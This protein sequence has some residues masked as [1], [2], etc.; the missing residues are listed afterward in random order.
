MPQPPRVSSTQ[1][2]W[3]GVAF[4]VVGIAVTSWLQFHPIVSGEAAMRFQVVL[5]QVLQAVTGLGVVLVGVSVVLRHLAAQ[6]PQAFA[7]AVEW[8][9]GTVPGSRR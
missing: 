4:I 7:D 2:L 5:F 8:D 1:A 9:E 3:A 6:A